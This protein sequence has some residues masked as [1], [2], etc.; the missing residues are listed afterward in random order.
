[1]AI[2]CDHAADDFALIDAEL[3]RGRACATG[4]ALPRQ[5]V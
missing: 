3:A 5:N 4:P 2:G 1:M